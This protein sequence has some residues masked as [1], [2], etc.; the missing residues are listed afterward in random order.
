MR[1]IKTGWNG[2][3][4]AVSTVLDRL[5]VFEYQCVDEW[6]ARG[7]SEKLDRPDSRTDPTGG[8]YSRSFSIL[9]D[10]RDWDGLKDWGYRWA[11]QDVYDAVAE[12]FPTH[13]FPYEIPS[14]PPEDANQL[15]TFNTLAKLATGRD[16]LITFD[17]FR[18]LPDYGKKLRT[19]Q[20]DPRT[21]LAKRPF[22]LYERK[23]RYMSYKSTFKSFEQVKNF[24]ERSVWDF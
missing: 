20:D 24:C 21:Q 8:L 7:P 5:T 19:Y 9:T 4:E 23:G 14:L 11:S 12:V 10:F 13:E 22:Y 16:I 17:P 3:E 1:T 2:R 18:A 15:V 6:L